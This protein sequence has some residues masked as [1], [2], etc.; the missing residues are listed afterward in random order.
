M[1]ALS[2]AARPATM[3]AGAGGGIAQT[4]GKPVEPLAFVRETRGGRFGADI[5]AG[6]RFVES[7]NL[8][9]ED[10]FERPQPR[11]RAVEAGIEPVQF[12]PHHPAQPGRRA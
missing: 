5:G 9:F 10:G 4:S 8:V 2:C 11:E 1:L 12:P 6:A 3:F 7:G